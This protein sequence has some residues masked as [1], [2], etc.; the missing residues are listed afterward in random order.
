MR[1]D[2]KNIENYLLQIWFHRYVEVKRFHVLIWTVAYE[3]GNHCE[4]TQPAE[5]PILRK[6]GFHCEALLWFRTQVSLYTYGLSGKRIRSDMEAHIFL[7]VYAGLLMCDT[8]TAM[9]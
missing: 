7:Y 3:K 1:W 4:L 8:H 9:K 6:K 5:P 2:V